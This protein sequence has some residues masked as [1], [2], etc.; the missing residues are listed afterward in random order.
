VAYEPRKKR[1]QKRLEALRGEQSSKGWRSHWQELGDLIL[2][3]RVLFSLQDTNRGEK[4]Q[5]Q[6]LDST[7]SRSARVLSAG[8]MSGLTSPARPWFRLASP[9]PELNRYGPVKQWMTDVQREMER[10]FAASNL[11]NVL[12]SMYEAV[13]VFGTACAFAW[14]DAI[15]SRRQTGQNES[16][17]RFEEAPIGSFFIAT[18]ARGYVDT[19]YR[20]L[21]MTVGQV[22]EQFGVARC[23]PTLQNL[24]ARGMTDSW[25]DIVHAIEPNDREASPFASGKVFSSCWYEAGATG[26]GMLRESGFDE[27]PGLVPRWWVS[28]R[29]VYGR[30]PGM[31]VL[32]DAKQLQSQERR[33]LQAVELMT[34]PSRVASKDAKSDVSFLPGGVSVTDSLDARTAMA[35]P[36]V[37]QIPID[38]L[39]IDINE[40]R[41]RI[42]FGFSED[43]FLML[44]NVDREV[45]ATE[46]AERKEEK[47]L[48]L[49]PVLERLEDELLDPLIDRTFAVMQRRGRFLPGSNLEPPEEL[50]GAELRIEYVSILAQAQRA[51]GTSSMDRLAQRFAFIAPLR[52]DVL[53]KWDVD[54]D[55]ED[56]A[57]R[58]GVNPKVL[59]SEDEVEEDRA[60]RV[61]R[62]RMASLAAAAPGIAGAAK[63]LSE[64]DLSNPDSAAARAMQAVGAA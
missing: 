22:V 49:G 17:V 55:I 15:E 43:L 63:D 62:E 24:Y 10:V 50:S 47:L 52:P 48:M 32:P 26:D 36:F 37:P 16:V 41:Q 1:Y 7:A 58:L 23:S 3:R 27:F 53:D 9:D 45:T 31:E 14:D 44:T 12:P 61:Q 21:Q 20:E 35:V 19:V 13:G 8:M 11:Y 40:V 56:Y 29:D 6:I 25:I 42:R 57:E 34:N 4:R 28:G 30:S 59:R 54:A 64:T 38:E 60:A 5:T 18:S 51:V 46:I 33:K 2:P 39:R